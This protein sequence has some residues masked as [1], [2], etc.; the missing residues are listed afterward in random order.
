MKVTKEIIDRILQVIDEKGF[1]K[2]E[3]SKELGYE[4]NKISEI[5]NGYTKELTNQF[6]LIMK[7]RFGINPQWLETGTGEKYVVYEKVQDPNELKLVRHYRSVN[8]KFQERLLDSSYTC[9]LEWG[10]ETGYL[11]VSES[12]PSYGKKKD[13]GDDPE[14]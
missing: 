3:F 7:L 1:S 13:E 14:N 11:S 10:L 4:S 6:M 2:A 9:Y 8:P 12:K 5:V